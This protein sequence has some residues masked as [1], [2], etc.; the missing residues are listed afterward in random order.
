MVC[1]LKQ[2]SI[3]QQYKP[4]A[5]WYGVNLQDPTDWTL[6]LI[7][8][9]C[10]SRAYYIVLALVVQVLRQW[11]LQVA[12]RFC[13][14]CTSCA[15]FLCVPKRTKNIFFLY[16]VGRSYHLLTKGQRAFCSSYWIYCIVSHIDTLS[17]LLVP[18]DLYVL[19]VLYIPQAM[20]VYP[21]NTYRSFLIIVTV[22]G[23]PSQ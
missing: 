3:W 9:N 12:E 2:C 14:L 1:G 6:T 23:F 13:L 19:L 7:S 22:C 5:A 20:S 16:G 8:C 10:V 18:A 15:H 11:F 21:P 17:V 4:Q